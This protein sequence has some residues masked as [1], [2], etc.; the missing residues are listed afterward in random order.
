MWNGAPRGRTRFAAARTSWNAF[1]VVNAPSLVACMC[2][3]SITGRTQGSRDEMARTSSRLPKSLTRP[4]ISTPNGTPRSLRLDPLAEVCELR[5]DR[6][7]RLLV[8]P[9]EEESR[10][11]DDRLCAGDLRDPGRVV[12]HAGRHPV[13]AVALDVAHE[14]GDRRVHGERDPPLAA[15]ASRTPRPTGSPSRS[16]TR[17]RSRSPCSRARAAAR[18]PPPAIPATAPAP[19]RSEASPPVAT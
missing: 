10:M 19:G 6:G 11:E 7:D 16:R 5:D 4:M 2:A 14:P 18:S 12:E 9:A 3:K 15:R 1:T 17:S 13:L 8:R